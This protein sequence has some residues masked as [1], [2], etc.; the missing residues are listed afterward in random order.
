MTMPCEPSAIAFATAASIADA[1]IRCRD[2]ERLTVGA[3]HA[4]QGRAH[5]VQH[6][7]EI[8]IEM[9]DTGAAIARMTRGAMRLGP[10]PSRMRSVDGS[11]MVSMVSGSR[12]ADER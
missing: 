8:R 4:L 6:R 1:A 12:Q 9:T 5:L 2:R 10:G 7:D 3:E 11:G